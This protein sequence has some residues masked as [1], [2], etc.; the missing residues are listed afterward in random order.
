MKITPY[1]KQNVEFYTLYM[2]NIT[3]WHK[4]E[5]ST[6]VKKK[7]VPKYNGLTLTIHFKLY[8]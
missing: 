7:T 5:I 3:S 8:F 4:I 6:Y 2:A 1:K